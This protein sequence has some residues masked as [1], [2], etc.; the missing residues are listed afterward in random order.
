MKTIISYAWK[1]AACAAAYMVGTM[2]GGAMASALGVGL[3]ATPPGGEPARL[4]LFAFLASLT[5]GASLGPL[6]SGLRA[7]YLT[8]W[9]ALGLL[10]YVCLGVN[11]AL[12]TTIFTTIGGAVGMCVLFLPATLACA[13]AAA[14]L[15]RP[16]EG[17]EAGA[18]SWSRFRA[19]FGARSWSVRLAAAI[20][21]FPVV[22]LAFGMLVGPF[23]VEAY[24]NQAHGLTLPGWGQ[25]IPIV[26][27][28]SL[29][30]LAASLPAIVLWHGSRR[31]LALSLGLAHYAFVGLFGMLQASWLPTA[32]RLAHGAEIAADSFAYASL[33]VLLLVRPGPPAATS[34]PATSRTAA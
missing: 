17:P 15:F 33:L 21:A 18:S 28:R 22:Y 20:L 32:M 10:A 25:I 19:Q 2:L 29:L 30:F 8:R 1:T 13:A 11:T 4:A 34:A 31:R 24:K 12:E 23:V 7:R 3:P 5:L 27:L 9:A 14:A 16:D 26:L 6:A